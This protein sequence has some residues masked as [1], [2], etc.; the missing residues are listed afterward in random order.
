MGR[1]A[2]AAFNH[3]VAQGH[4]VLDVVNLN[5]ELIN[6]L[7]EL[8]VAQP[9]YTELY[10]SWVDMPALLRFLEDRKLT[11]SVTVRAKQATGVII[12]TQGELTGAYTTEARDVAGDV[13]GVLSSRSDAEAMVAV[14]SAA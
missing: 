3:Q 12:L 14:K 4:G 10:A 6:G 5:P 13:N 8:T 7:Y 9:I 11:G 1:P 2:L